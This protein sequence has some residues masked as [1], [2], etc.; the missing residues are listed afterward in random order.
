MNGLLGLSLREWRR[1]IREPAR[2]IGTIATPVL[3][4]LFMIGGFGGLGNVGNEVSI[5]GYTS[6]G[7]ALAVCL[8]STVF[9]SIGF[10]QDREDGFLQAVLVSPVPRVSIALSKMLV[11]GALAGV[12]GSIIL[13][14]GAI[15]AG[16]VKPAGLLLG[17]GLLIWIGIGT[18]ALGLFFAS[19]IRSASG[20]HSIMSLVLLPMWALSGSLFPPDGAARWM[21]LVMSANPM[22]WAHACL[23]DVLAIS[24]AH[25]ALFWAGTLLTPVVLCALA[26]TS[27]SRRERGAPVT[28]NKDTGRL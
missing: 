17:V 28:L 22:R 10:I 24:E 9:A 1:F 23:N 14:A 5:A 8:F 26:T 11:G 27:I 2:I 25:S 16:N 19:R 15:A 6:V 7:A 12:Q 18:V 13:I 3:L 21:E 20:F 4:W